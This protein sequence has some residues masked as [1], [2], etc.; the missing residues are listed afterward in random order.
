MVKSKK[1]VSDIESAEK[2]VAPDMFEDETKIESVSDGP[3]DEFHAGNEPAAAGGNN[4]LIRQIMDRN[5]MEYASYVIKERAIPD[6]DDGLKPVQRRILWSLYRMDDGK[7]HK[8]ANVIGHTMQ[9]HPHGD[10]SIG[11]ALVVLA[12][13]N[14]YIDRQGNFGN[15]LTGDPAS[16]A[17]YIECRLSPL[18]RAVL[19]NN[20]IT[21]FTDSYDGR[22]QEPIRLPVKIPSMLILG[23]EGIA[24]GMST[25]IPPHNFCEVLRAQIAI[26]K[27]EPFVLYPDFIQGGLMDISEYDR[28]QGKLKLRAKIEKD[29]RRLVIREVPAGTTTESLIASIESAAEKNKIKI[30][31]IS[32]FTTENVEIEIV[33]SRGYEPDKALNALYAYTDCQV[34]FSSNIL[35]IQDSRPKVMTVDAVLLR[36]TE[37][38]LTYLF[39][40]L[41]FEL[42]KLLAK[43]HERTLERIFIEE[44]IYKRIE[45][46]QLKSEVISEIFNG[47]AVFADIIRREVTEADIERLLSIPIRRISLFDMQKNLDEIITIQEALDLNLSHLKR[48]NHYAVDYLK[49]LLK[50]YGP[51]YPRRTEITA[52]EK[53]NLK[54][55]ALSN[56]KVG[57]DRKGCYVG[58]N[59]KSDETVTCTEYDRLLC[60]D[61]GGSYRVIR[62]PEKLFVDKLY[63]FRKY[64]SQLGFCMV[65]TDKKSG[66]AYWKRFQIDKAVTDK[67]YTLCPP[68]CRIDLLTPRLNAEFEVTLEGRSEP[69]VLKLWEA[70]ERSARSRGLLIDSNPF[71]A[72]RF[73]RLVE[74]VEVVFGNPAEDESEADMPED[75]HLDDD[76]DDNDNGFEGEWKIPKKNMEPIRELIREAAELAEHYLLHNA[77]PLTPQV[78]PIPTAEPVAEMEAEVDAPP[79]ETEPIATSASIIVETQTITNKPEKQ[80]RA[81]HDKNQKNNT[82]VESESVVTDIEPAVV[83][84]KP[85]KSKRNVNIEKMP[86]PE[87]SS[88]E[89]SSSPKKESAEDLWGMKQMDFGF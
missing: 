71:V 47:L 24:V 55:A 10:A 42:E 45:Q 87:P 69:V 35:V 9:F 37:K 76:N 6:V 33:P 18:G 21:E 74:G 2:T 14:L 27:N 54:A 78:I 34:S 52:F 75:F 4:A 64:D 20:D 72:I 79:L 5:F 51:A 11:D 8:V 67:N 1:Q 31:S 7:S 17:R 22:N 63:D 46:C 19:F 85:E 58:R 68:G 66:K 30:Q 36:N 70:T 28:G 88:S 23:A 26:L 38:L 84:V 61:R 86:P 56:I 40:E 81:R 15:V 57:L 44:R 48:L 49:M 41:R 16:A 77:L 80:T 65:Y 29:G 25:S 39:A 32:D 89:T 3:D 60:I 83:H 62:I 59:V 82:I 50:Q 12:N 53:I 73:A 43:L 13:K